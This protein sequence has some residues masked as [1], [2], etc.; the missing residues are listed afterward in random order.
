[1]RRF[2]AHV[3]LLSLGLA[4]GLA[5][6]GDEYS[7][8]I[9][10]RHPQNV[11]WGD[12]HLHTNLSVDAYAFGNRNLGPEEAYR[13]AKGEE[14]TT[15]NGMRVRLRRPLDFLVIAD[16]S[17]NMGLLS[18]LERG[19]SG[20]LLPSRARDW[21]E[22]FGAAYQAIKGDPAKAHGFWQVV[23][24][25][26]FMGGNALTTE[27]RDS[28]WR[29]FAYLADAHNEPGRF[30]ALIGYEWTQWYE[31][32]H[33]V[34]IFR[35]DAKKATRM[36]PFT[37]YDSS[38]PEDLW[39]YLENYE[40]RTG[41]EVL[42]IPHNSNLTS[43]TMFALEDA[44]GN[45]LT[46]SYA[47]T[48]Q[49]WEPLLEVTQVKGDSETHPLLSPRDSFADFERQSMPLG[50][51]SAD[52][53]KVFGYTGFDSWHERFRNETTTDWMRHFE[54]ARSA[55]KLGL[56]QQ[57]KL[58]V[59]P[60]KFGMIGSSDMHTSLS[61]TDEDNFWGGPSSASGPHPRRLLGPWIPHST[62]PARREG[63]GAV[64]WTM[65]AS[66]KAAVW[67]ESNTREALFAA[68]K[69]RETY[70]TTGPRMSVR[71]FGGW[72]FASTDAVQPDLARVGYRKGVPMGGDLANGPAGR[73]PSF[74]VRAVK[75]PEGANLD[76]LQ[77][78][79]GWRRKDGSLHEKVYDVA[80][81][82]GRTPDA[83]GKV[84][85]VG[86]TVNLT[87][88]SYENSIGAPEL[89]VVWKDPDFDPGELAFY[90]VRVIE[91]PT[92]KWTAYDAKYFGVKNVPPEVPLVQQER[93]YTSPIWF[94]PAA[95]P[96]RGPQRT[97]G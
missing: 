18:E 42:A 61:T 93:A 39:T 90:Y 27:A 71:F 3:V 79:K 43:G 86:S 47:E 85:P 35:D 53:K 63:V 36:L 8:N 6:A 21:S 24:Y 46:R 4:A 62:R 12:T 31:W 55:L 45:A 81:S 49:R 40:K 94:T 23:S 97:P 26:G 2:A 5:S 44:R 60:F 16:H 41:G 77:I 54:Y 95:T 89:A 1:M 59:N 17:G 64:G 11:Y 84:R 34:V 83:T 51:R 10:P 69:R 92:P 57:A 15:Q 9:G 73:A 29:K 48:R 33:R 22:R 50:A 56:E 68:M 52:D 13:F 20:V 30:T 82:D 75:D 74:L 66:G 7:P 65:G 87:N 14:V 32:L 38:D 37:E 91:I 25:S 67:A 80:L 88:V 58:G 19:N 72:D 70:A 28:I 78:V 76:R 96:S